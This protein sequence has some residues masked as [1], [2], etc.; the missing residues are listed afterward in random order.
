MAKSTWRFA[1]CAMALSVLAACSS[2]PAPVAQVDLDQIVTHGT[3]RVCSTGDYRPFTYH[4][5]QG[6][7]GLDIEMAQDLAKNLGVKLDLVQTT[8]ATMVSDLGAKC[9]VAMGGV[10]ITLD[11]AKRARYSSP[12]LRDGKAA[13]I[14]CADRPKYQ[15]LA[16][17]D[18]P[19]VRIVVNPGGTNAEFDAANIDHATIV[20]YRDNN[21]IFDQVSGG[22]ADVMITDTS[23]IRWQTIQ[24]PQL[25][26]VGL[27]HP[28]TF[29]QKAYL[30][31]EASPALQQWTDQWLNIAQN[32]GTFAH[33]S[34][35]WVGVVSQ[36]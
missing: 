26:G 34:Q 22:K 3:V 20:K 31:P 19:G 10:S 21:T 30:I 25:C 4:D 33:I 27:D 36:P 13:A 1:A 12:Y 29:E 16:D 15:T 2:P 5:A 35:K 23:E 8:W 9:D 14:R 28:F 11:R 17:I 7:S 32:D 24:N 18:R 6:W